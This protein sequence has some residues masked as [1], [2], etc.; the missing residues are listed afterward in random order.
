MNGTSFYPEITITF[1]VPYPAR[2][3]HIPPLIGPFGYTTYRG[4]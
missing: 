3:H 2:R 4:S 1:G